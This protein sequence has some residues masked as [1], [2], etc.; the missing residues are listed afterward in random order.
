MAEVANKQIVVG[1]GGVGKSRI[2][3]VVRVRDSLSFRLFDYPIHYQ[4]VCHRL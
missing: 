1:A 3:F 4:Q 2:N